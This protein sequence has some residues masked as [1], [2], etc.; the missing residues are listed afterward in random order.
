MK[1]IFTFL[2]ACMMCCSASISVAASETKINPPMIDDSAFVYE[3]AEYANTRAIR[4]EQEPNE[5]A[6]NADIINVGDTMTGTI[7]NSSDIDR[8]KLVPTTTE[9]I[10]I[11]LSGPSGT[12]YDYDLWLQDKSGNELKRSAESGSN[13]SITYTV[14]KGVTYYIVVN[15]AKGY[16]P[17]YTAKVKGDSS[18]SS[19]GSLGIRRFTQENRN[20][21]WAAAVQMMCNYETGSYPTQSAIVTQIYGSA[22]DK[23]GTPSDQVK[24]LKWYDSSAFRNA[25]YW[26]ASTEAYFNKYV[27]ANYNKGHATTLACTTTSGTGHALVVDEI[28]GSYVTLIDPWANVSNH[29]VTKQTL[30]NDGFYCS[31][32]GAN[33]RSTA[34]TVY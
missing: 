11:T 34:C 8:F 30:L 27:V 1:R 33:V 19:S 7:G 17:S 28:S 23:T 5:G 16:G 2:L 4:E 20:W 25:D 18:S 29:R 3:K 13:G 24:V 6:A 22:V 31:A 12:S 9:T 14:S 26:D 32:V 21:C 10:T 15:S